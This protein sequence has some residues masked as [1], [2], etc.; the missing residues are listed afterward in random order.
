MGPVMQYILCPG[1]PNAGPTVR[2]AATSRKRCCPEA[3]SEVPLLQLPAV[4]VEDPITAYFIRKIYRMTAPSS[5]S[6]LL[7]SKYS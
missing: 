4:T 7:S 6:L 1:Q 5:R 3:E 2:T